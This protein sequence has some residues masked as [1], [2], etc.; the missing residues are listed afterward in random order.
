MC[1]RV[2]SEREGGGQVKPRTMGLGLLNLECFHRV[3]QA[4]LFDVQSIERA[5]LDSRRDMLLSQADDCDDYSCGHTYL[6]ARH[7]L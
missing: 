4:L 1:K 5:L 7:W 3:R 2:P 6:L